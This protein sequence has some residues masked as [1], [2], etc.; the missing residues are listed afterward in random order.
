MEMKKVL[1]LPSFSDCEMPLITGYQTEST[2]SNPIIDRFN[3]EQN[4]MIDSPYSEEH[5]INCQ[6]E[7]KRLFG[8]SSTT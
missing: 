3:L 7:C 8:L 4:G 6:Q 5:A 1:R 2:T